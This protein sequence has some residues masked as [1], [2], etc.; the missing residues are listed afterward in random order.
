MSIQKVYGNKMIL[1]DM[2]CDTILKVYENQLKGSSEKYNHINPTKL[3]AAGIDIQFFAIFAHTL[4]APTF[5]HKVLK[6]I[7]FY[8]QYI[9]YNNTFF[10][11]LISKKDIFKCLNN[12]KIGAFLTIEG[13]EVLEGDVQILRVLYHLGVRGLGLTWNHRNQ[14]AD[15]VEERQTGGGLTRF[16]REIVKEMNRLGMVIDVSHLSEKGF[17][18]V[19]ELSATPVIASHSNC[20]SIWNHPRNLTDEQIKGLA[21]KKGIIGLNFVPE[22]LGPPGANLND[23]LK[24][25][26]HLCSLVGDDFLGFGSDFDGTDAI[27]PE[28]KDASYYPV[29]I[30]ALYRLGY[31]DITIRKICGENC[32][33]VLDSILI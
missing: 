30:E 14:I 28:I 31:S 23:L 29:I 11:P 25:I 33:R 22:F 26:D 16:G 6:L 3:H 7:D 4:S 32:L 19:L 17:W 1:I 2:H 15:G 9:E 24:H 27:I 18:D 20:S 21:Q 8:Y 12:D 5:L 13:G 10:I